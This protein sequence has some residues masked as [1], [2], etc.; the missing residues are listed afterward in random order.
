VIAE[1]QP[2]FGDAVVDA[3]SGAKFTAEVEPVMDIE[4]NMLLGRDARESVI[5][6]VA[7]RGAA[8]AVKMS[9][10]LQA[11]C[12]EF[13]VIRRSDNPASPQVDFGAM[14]VSD[15]DQ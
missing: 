9:D 7:D 11:L 1:R 15:K 6:H 14:K 12:G 13:I 4:S 2:T 10:V 5:F 8:V 3:T